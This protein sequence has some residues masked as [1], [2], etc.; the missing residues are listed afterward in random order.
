MKRESMLEIWEGQSRLVLGINL[1]KQWDH[2]IQRIIA[3]G[4]VGSWHQLRYWW[5]KKCVPH[6]HNNSD[7]LS[8][9]T[10]RYGGVCWSGVL[11]DGKWNPWRWAERSQDEII[12]WWV[13]LKE[14]TGDSQ[15]RSSHWFERFWDFFW[16][17]LFNKIRN[18]S[19]HQL[20]SPIPP[21]S[22]SYF[23]FSP[24]S[25]SF[26]SWEFIIWDLCKISIFFLFFL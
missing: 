17:N 15:V 1:V 9:G 2:K 20:V 8:R 12:T 16:W 26:T 14:W 19:H 4:G 10:Q 24:Y 7:P 25:P 18:L 13:D 3:W 22:S 6:P 5:V 23:S 11:E 21:L